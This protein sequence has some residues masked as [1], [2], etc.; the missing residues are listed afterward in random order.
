MVA[1]SQFHLSESQRVMLSSPRR[2]LD[3]V[4]VRIMPTTVV[5]AVQVG[6]VACIV[7]PGSLEYNS[8]RP[9]SVAIIVLI[10][11]AESEAY[12]ITK[13]VACR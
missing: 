2:P 1:L 12:K 7:P 11:R 9:F 5:V 8:A 3:A 6:R 10:E 4:R 13:R